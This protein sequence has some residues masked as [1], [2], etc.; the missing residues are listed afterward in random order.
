MLDLEGLFQK[1]LAEFTYNDARMVGKVPYFWET[2]Q[3]L[4]EEMKVGHVDGICATFALMSRL[5]LDEVKVA[6]TLLVC[7]VETGELHL[8]CSV[9]GTIFDN[10]Q[11]TLMT[12]TSLE[13]MGYVFLVE[14]SEVKGGPWYS[15]VK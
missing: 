5:A 4:L 14:S 12:N 9:N 15:I 7:T 2:D 1:L 8:V 11:K 6:N 3:Q 10:R 13:E